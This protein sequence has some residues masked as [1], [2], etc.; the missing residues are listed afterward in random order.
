MSDKVLPPERDLRAYGGVA[1]LTM[2]WGS[3]FFLTEI[4]LRGIS[5]LGIAAGRALLSALALVVLSRSLGVALPKGARDWGW[6]L[7]LGIFAIAL[8]FSLLSWGQLN[9]SSGVAAIFIAGSPLFILLLSRFVL[10]D[11]VSLRQWTGFVI[12]LAG[13]VWLAGP[14]ALASLGQSGQILPQLACVGAAAC[15]AVASITVKLMPPLHPLSATTGS[16]ITATA[17][18]LPVG[19][20]NLPEAMP[21]LEPLAALLVLGIVQTGIAQYL[22]F[23]TVKRAGPV[24]VSTVGY[25]I[26][27]WAGL[28]GLVFLDEVLT[29]RN[30]TAY[31]LIIGGLLLSRTRP[32]P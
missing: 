4:A 1:L 12:G 10:G 30:V 23:A 28:L 24:F 3:S 27:I 15:Y 14:A 16:Q 21:E 20:L 2:I 8:P 29:A 11:A 18:L 19:Y 17:L 7:L 6:C 31:A 13:L 25:L 9:V 26:P 22:R 5:P 32:K